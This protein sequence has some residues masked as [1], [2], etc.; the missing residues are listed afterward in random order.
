MQ[1]ELTAVFRRDPA[2]GFAAYVADP[3][4]FLWEIAWNPAWPISHNDP[5]A[6]RPRSRRAG[7][8]PAAIP[9]AAAAPGT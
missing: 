4:G 7:P 1:L 2:G 5:A 8:S 3:E 9:R 6:S